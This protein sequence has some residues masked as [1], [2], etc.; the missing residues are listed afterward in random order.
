MAYPYAGCMG[1]S[2]S[3]LRVIGARLAEIVAIFS[4]NRQLSVR[5]HMRSSG[6]ERLP[7]LKVRRQCRL[8][9]HRG[10]IRVQFRPT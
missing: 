4:D 8:V 5:A 9:V 1:S 7:S 2:A 6:E 3:T 10:V